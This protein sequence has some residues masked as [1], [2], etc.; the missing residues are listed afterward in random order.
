MSKNY[1]K[2]KKILFYIILAIL[3]LMTA[4]SSY[5]I[6]NYK[7]FVSPLHANYNLTVMIYNKKLTLLETITW[8]IYAKKY[9]VLLKKWDEPLVLNENFNQISSHAHV[10]VVKQ[11]STNAISFIKQYDGKSYLMNENAASVTSLPNIDVST[12]GILPMGLINNSL[13]NP[14]KYSLTGMYYFIPQAKAD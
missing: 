2:N 6:L 7:N 9:K 4:L 1:E 3:I 5:F 11:N 14:N 10:R 8:K 12:T 13:F